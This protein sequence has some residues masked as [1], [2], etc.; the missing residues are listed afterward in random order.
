MTMQATSSEYLTTTQTIP[1]DFFQDRVTNL[2][3]GQIILIVGL[4]QRHHYQ[5]CKSHSHCN[6]FFSQR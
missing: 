2:N 5:M 4:G 1:P 6:V 3:L